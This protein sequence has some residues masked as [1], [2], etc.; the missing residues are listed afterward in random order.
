MELTC[1]QMLD[2]QGG[3]YGTVN[4]GGGGSQRES[5]PIVTKWEQL[6]LHP[7]LLRSLGKF[8]YVS[9]QDSITVIS[10]FLY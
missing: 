8:G 7:D 2:T 4:N 10:T 1:L 3:D 9:R 5:G 6:S